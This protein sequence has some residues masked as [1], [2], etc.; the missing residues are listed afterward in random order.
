M[1][2]GYTCSFS[3]Q[4]EADRFRPTHKFKADCRATCHAV[5]AKD[6]YYDIMAYTPLEAR[7]LAPSDR[8]VVFQRITGEPA[9]LF[10]SDKILQWI[11]YRNY[12]TLWNYGYSEWVKRE[13]VNDPFQLLLVQLISIADG[14][15][16]FP[17][18]FPE[19]A[20]DLT[21][22]LKRYLLDDFDPEE[23]PFPTNIAEL[24]TLLIDK[25]ARH[26]ADEFNMYL[27]KKEFEERG[28]KIKELL[29]ANWEWLWEY[30][31]KPAYVDQLEHQWA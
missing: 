28:Q 23:D 20:D 29:T 19:T 6:L 24:H 31:G 14:D 18:S 4:C 27:P 13:L 2:S 11:A 25:I 9:N 30:F 8:K 3:G 26:V 1:T 7:S 22:Y 5:A 10:G 21:E 12:H 17:R 16:P 15:N